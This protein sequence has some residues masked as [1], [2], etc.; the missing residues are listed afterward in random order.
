MKKIIFGVL[1][2]LILCTAIFWF[3]SPKNRNLRGSYTPSSDGKTY[4]SIKD[5]NGGVCKPLLV[6]GKEWKLKT[7]EAAVVSAGEHKI[8]CGK[9]DSGIG[10]IIPDGTIYSYDYW[11]P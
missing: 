5:D 3:L 4:L 6:D 7:D 10:F 2:L 9:A 11:G 1:G 8:Q